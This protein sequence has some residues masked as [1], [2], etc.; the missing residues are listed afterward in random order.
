VFGVI[1]SVAKDLRLPH[2]HN[3]RSVAALREDNRPG[4]KK[5]KKEKAV[6]AD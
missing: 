4:L 6:F 2:R 1:L 5:A 3:Y